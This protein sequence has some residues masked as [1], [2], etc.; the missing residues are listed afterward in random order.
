M[1]TE[2]I[3]AG[4]MIDDSPICSRCGMAYGAWELNLKHGNKDNFLNFV[5]RPGCSWRIGQHPKEF[6]QKLKDAGLI[7]SN[8]NIIR[9]Q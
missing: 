9:M 7:P 4:N 2:I 8:A 3:R 5:H 6:G 1:T